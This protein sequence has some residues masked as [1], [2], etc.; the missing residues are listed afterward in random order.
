MKGIAVVPN[1][2]DISLIVACHEKVHLILRDSY[3]TKT[4]EQATQFVPLYLVRQNINRN[5]LL[6]FGQLPGPWHH[7][8]QLHVLPGMCAVVHPAAAVLGKCTLRACSFVTWHVSCSDL[9]CMNAART[10]CTW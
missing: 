7:T 2:S 10:V 8:S 4:Y 3:G 9:A 6:H 5:L 1:A